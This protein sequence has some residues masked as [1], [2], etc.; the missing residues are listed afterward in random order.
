M[1]KMGSDK[2]QQAA[3]SPADVVAYLDRRRCGQ[4]GTS[5][6]SVSTS[7]ILLSR[8]HPKW[9]CPWPHPTCWDFSCPTCGQ[10]ITI[11]VRKGKA[12]P[13]GDTHVSRRS[14]KRR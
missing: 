12:G 11:W 13:F 1:D 8:H 10:A 6:G 9:R 14:P 5:L 3:D 2:L 7:E 4:C